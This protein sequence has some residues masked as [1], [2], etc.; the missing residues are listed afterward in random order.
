MDS[1]GL[2]AFCKKAAEYVLI[3]PDRL[4][5]YY[6]SLPNDERNM[7]WTS[8]YDTYDSFVV[9]AENATTA[10]NT[11]PKGGPIR[12]G[13]LLDEWPSLADDISQLIVTEIGIAHVG[14]EPGIVVASFNAG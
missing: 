13:G 8:S 3:A 11:H 12:K 6:V 10:R 1:Q 7:A 2:D 5:I 14:A 9:I 4:R